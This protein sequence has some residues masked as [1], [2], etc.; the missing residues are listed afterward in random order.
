MVGMKW[1]RAKIQQKWSYLRKQR[2]TPSG[3]FTEFVVRTYYSIDRCCRELGGN[4]CP[5]ELVSSR[6]I[7]D[8]VYDGIYPE[9]DHDYDGVIGDCKKHLTEMGYLHTEED[10]SITVIDKPLDFLLPG[11]HEA[12]LA[13]FGQE[14]R[15]V[16]K[17]AVRVGVRCASCGG[18]LVLRSGRYGL[19]FGCER[20]PQCKTVRSVADVTYDMLETAGLRLYSVTRP[21][22]KCMRDIEVMSY[23]P[24]L[25]LAEM[26]PE[27]ARPLEKLEVLRLSALPGLDERLCR[28]YVTLR[29]RYS[30]KAGFSYV[31]N[32]CPH[33]GALQG[34]QMTL[35]KVY[36]D[37]RE[38]A[39]RGTLQEHVREILPVTEETLPREAWKKTVEYLFGG[40]LL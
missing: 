35:G 4:R 22:W 5:S 11:E 1:S 39:A 27:L 15:R 32:S 34:S 23:F 30:K 40:T 7:K 21:C 6:R 9:P 24:Y 28:R 18:Q 19:F 12:Y 31:G 10:G 3:N 16:D 14:A 13:R 37:L 38:Y 36:R 25:D 26:E 33:C 29:E 2:E 20:F 8:A 17:T